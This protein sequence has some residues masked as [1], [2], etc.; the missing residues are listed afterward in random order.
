MVRAF[1]LHWRCLA[2]GG[3][4]ENSFVLTLR[5]CDWLQNSCERL[6]EHGQFDTGTGMHLFWCHSNAL[7]CSSSVL[8]LSGVS[9]NDSMHPPLLRL[10]SSQESKLQSWLMYTAFCVCFV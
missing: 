10:M 8:C 2:V 4:K 1:A 3:S 9:A 6:Q 7:H 5:L